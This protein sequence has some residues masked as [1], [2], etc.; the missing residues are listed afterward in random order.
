MS[1]E[2]QKAMEEFLAKGGKITYCPPCAAGERLPHID[3]AMDEKIKASMS[4]AAKA[5]SIRARLTRRATYNRKRK[6]GY[7][8]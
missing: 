3:E 1:R 8:P 6:D 2:G 7:A 5:A 4:R